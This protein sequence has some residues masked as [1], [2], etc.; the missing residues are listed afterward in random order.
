[1]EQ[2][3]K[4]VAIATAVIGLMVGVIAFRYYVKSNVLTREKQQLEK[5]KNVLQQQNSDLNKKVEEGRGEI[6]RLQKQA[7]QIKGERDKLAG[8]RDEL[9]KKFQVLSSERDKLMERLQKE[10]SNADEARVA[11]SAAAPSEPPAPKITPDEYW[12]GVLKEKENLELQLSALRDT[13]KNNQIKIDDLT[14]E[15]TSLDL[16][17]QRFTKEKID[18]ERQFEYNEKMVDSLSLQLV[19]EKDDKRKIVKQANLFKE[20]NYA[21]RSRVNELMSVKV[22]LERK[23]KDAEDKRVELTR[24]LTQMDQ[25]LQEK[26]SEIIDAKQDFGDIKKGVSPSSGSAV[27]LAPI[28]VGGA[29]G[30][31]IQQASSGAQPYQAPMQAA[32]QSQPAEQSSGKVISVSEENDFVIIDIGEQEGVYH[33]QVLTAYRGQQQIAALEIIEVRAHISAADIKEK[34]A[35]LKIGDIVR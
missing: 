26:L 31:G 5:D 11:A 2:K 7:T 27:E 3:I 17:V 34:T 18:R 29:A 28:V 35:S 12:A 9:D 1:M 20:E 14:R 23:F 30:A 13:I 6:G 33:G 10:V 21:L 32:A 4:I 25:L 15:K 22:S 24:R 16:E 8:E 19:R